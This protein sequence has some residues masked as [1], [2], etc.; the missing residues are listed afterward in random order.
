MN[1]IIVI[2]ISEMGNMGEWWGYDPKKREIFIF[3]IF[4]TTYILYKLNL[5]LFRKQTL[6][7]MDN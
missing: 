4:Y 5:M 2:V 7:D 3:F 6:L 1:I